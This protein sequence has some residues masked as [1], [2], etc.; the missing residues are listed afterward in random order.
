MTAWRK[1]YQRQSRVIVTR[2]LA[3]VVLGW[4]QGRSKYI[5]LV[6]LLDALCNVFHKQSVGHGAYGAP[7]K[8]YILPLSQWRHIAV[9]SQESRREK[10]RKCYDRSKPRDRGKRIWL[11]I[12]PCDCKGLGCRLLKR[13]RVHQRVVVAQCRFAM[14]RCYPLQLI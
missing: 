5:S 3:S 2:I 6:T 4:V 8:A 12:C 1:L 13:K 10:T 7:N 9:A 11:E 14:L